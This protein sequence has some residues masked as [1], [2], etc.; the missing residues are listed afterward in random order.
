MKSLEYTGLYRDALDIREARDRLASLIFLVYL[1]YLIEP[2][3]PDET[4]KILP[5]PLV[6]RGNSA[7]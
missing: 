5:V 2:D 4:D 7:G 3:R 6:S 1:V